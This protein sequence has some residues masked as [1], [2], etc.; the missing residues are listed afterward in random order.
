[1]S[2]RSFSNPEFLVRR[3][4]EMRYEKEMK[5]PVTQWL[6]DRGFEVG[7]ELMIS[8]YAD[9]IGFKFAERIGRRI[10]ELLQAVVVELKLWDVKGVICQARCNKYRIGESWAAMPKDFCDH[11][12]K[13]WYDR[14]VHEHIGLLS[15]NA[16][17]EVKI[18]IRPSDNLA[19]ETRG[20][21]WLREKFWRVHRQNEKI[22][23]NANRT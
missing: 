20:K 23:Y 19:I 21:N 8:G 16:D 5:L 2:R 10:P 9:V 13:I 12:S 22:E 6:Q 14:F 7:Y 17:G 4:K 1:M 15:V 3:I 18:V 11:M